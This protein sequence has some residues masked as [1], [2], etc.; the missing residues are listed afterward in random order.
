MIIIL[1][2]APGAGKG[3]QAKLIKNEL[4]IIHL[5]TG[6]ILRKEI[7][8]K[9]EIGNKAKFYIDKGEFIPDL[10]ILEIIQRR[11]TCSDCSN[12]YILDGFPRTL[13]QAIGLDKI[14]TELNQNLD[15]GEE[16]TL[17]SLELATQNTVHFGGKILQKDSEIFLCLG[18]LNSPGNSAKFDT[19]WGKIFSFEKESL[20][21]NPITSHDDN[22][23]KYIA[24]GLRNPWSCFF[25]N[26]NLI[27]PDVGNSH[28]EEVNILKNY[29][30]IVDP[31]FFGWPWLEAYFDANY[32]NTP[33]TEEVKNEQIE[34]T[35][36]PNYLFPHGNDYCAII[37]GTTQ[38]IIR[39]H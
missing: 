2:G 6:E 36:Y 26:N 29:N 39:K 14:I 4:G 19:A 37:G 23:I 33:V 16:Q 31:Y 28:W 21:E 15:I 10:T 35:I 11:L 13:P 3:T 8:N 7:E 12:G 9:T 30:N 5:S 27:I 1:F 32:K 18:D 24:Y 22:R 38:Y 17:L 25:N 20:I 34:N